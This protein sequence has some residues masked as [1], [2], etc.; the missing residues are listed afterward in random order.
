MMVARTPEA[1][2]SPY[3]PELADPASDPGEGCPDFE[4]AH[5]VQADGEEEGGHEGHEDWGLELEPPPQLGAPSTKDD[6]ESC[7]SHEG[8]DHTQGE[9]QSLVPDLNAILPSLARC[10]QDLQGEDGEDA[11]HEVQEDAPE[12]G[13][14]QG[15]GQGEPFGASSLNCVRG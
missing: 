5:E 11:G 13:E 15:H 2:D 1:S 4:Q 14:D 9:H 12:E 6:Q 8:Q 7:Q 10:S 3:P